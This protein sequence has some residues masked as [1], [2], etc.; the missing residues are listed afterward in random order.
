MEKKE[1]VIVSCCLIID[2]LIDVTPTITS[3]SSGCVFPCHKKK[4]DFRLGIV[5]RNT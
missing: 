5:N 1:L 4:K 2:E 3:S